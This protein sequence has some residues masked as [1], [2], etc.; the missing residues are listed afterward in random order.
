[1]TDLERK[2]VQG[3]GWKTVPDDSGGSQPGASIVRGPFEIAF[4]DAG[5]NDGIEFFTP[6]VGDI[7]LD[8]W[9]EIDTAWDQTA[10]GQIGTFDGST[11]GII[12]ELADVTIADTDQ[13]GYGAGLLMNENSPAASSNDASAVYR[14]VPGKFIAATPLKVCVSADG[15]AGGADPGASEGVARVYIITSTPVAFA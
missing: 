11:F 7:L 10:K 15:A 8:A 3:E 6:T 2:F 12:Y 1:M 9:I 4:D 5:L 14:I 13:H